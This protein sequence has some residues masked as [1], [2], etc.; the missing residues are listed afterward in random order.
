MNVK[1]D[2]ASAR[3]R[4]AVYL[5][6]AIPKGQAKIVIAGGNF[7]GRTITI[8]SFSEA[9]LATADFG[10]FTPGFVRVPFGDADAVRE[11]IDDRTAAVLIEPI[12]GERGVIIPPKG[13]LQSVR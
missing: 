8:I 4:S 2:R 1:I 3:T 7:H 6:E 11:V 10:P 9:P 12:Q 13:Y 5:V